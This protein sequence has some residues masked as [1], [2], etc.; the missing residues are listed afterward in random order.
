MLKYISIFGAW[1]T[2]RNTLLLT[3]YHAECGCS[4]SNRMGLDR[5]H[6]IGGRW[7]GPLGWGVIEQKKY[8]TPQNLY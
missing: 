3:S 2:P 6:K 5:G 8:A 1:L 7:T 4:M